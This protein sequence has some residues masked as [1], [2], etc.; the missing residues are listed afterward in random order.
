MGATMAMNTLRR[1]SR[2]MV[3]GI[4]MDIVTATMTSL[5]GILT[6]G[7]AAFAQLK[8]RGCL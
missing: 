4:G 5:R 3:T 8:S 2:G 1:M 7:D 6:A